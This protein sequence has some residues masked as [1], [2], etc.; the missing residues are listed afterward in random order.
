LIAG[1][2]LIRSLNCGRCFCVAGR[3]YF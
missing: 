1:L 3:R 2:S